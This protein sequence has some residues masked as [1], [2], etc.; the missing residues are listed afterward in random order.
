MTNEELH[1]LIDFLESK[2]SWEEFNKYDEKELEGLEME[3]DMNERI[4]ER[5][6]KIESILEYLS[7][8]S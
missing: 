7:S 3:E 2:V 8:D 1:K 4:W 5:I 6:I